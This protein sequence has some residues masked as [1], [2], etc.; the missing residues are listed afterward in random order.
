MANIIEDIRI[1]TIVI[2]SKLERRQGMFFSCWERKPHI[3]GKWR[4]QKE[5]QRPRFESWL[6]PDKLV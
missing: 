1:L 3:H 2:T 6:A 4:N 5:Q